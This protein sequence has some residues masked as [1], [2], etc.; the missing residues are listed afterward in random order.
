MLAE[1]EQDSALLDDV[2]ARR[3]SHLLV[4]LPRSDT[5]ER[6]A[7]MPFVAELHA[8]LNRRK[9]KPDDL[10]KGPATFQANGG[11]LVSCV[12]DDSAKPLFERQTL[13][14][15]GLQPLLAENPASISIAVCG[16][17]R[18]RQAA[19]SIALYAAWVNGVHLP[20]RKKKT[21]GEP[22]KTI[23]LH[24]HRENDGFAAL[25]AQ[26]EGNTLCRELTVLPPNELTPG[27]YRERL[28]KRAKSE[29][30]GIEELDMKRLRKMGAGAFV[31]VA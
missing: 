13:V 4:M 7:R 16:A 17:A 30:W 23:R 12:M 11:T 2:S 24:G 25:R 8:A 5:L 31:A 20:Q 29:A 15:K 27:A 22:L 14:R 9:K 3:A 19:A 18:E 26:A 6:F 1:L 10:G 28:R 21:E